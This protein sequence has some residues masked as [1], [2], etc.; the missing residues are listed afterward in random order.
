MNLILGPAFGR[1]D[2]G[3]AAQRERQRAALAGARQ[4][5]GLLGLQ[6]E[7]DGA[8]DEGVD[9]LFFLRRLIDRQ[10]TDVGEN[11]FGLDGVASAALRILFALGEDD[12]DAVVGQDE[13]AGAGFRRDFSGDG[14]HPGRQDRGHEAG[15][16]GLHQL[17]FADRLARNEGVARN[18]ARDLLGGLRA[19][20]ALDEAAARGR[21]RPGLPLQIVRLHR[22]AEADLVLGDENVDRL[23]LCD[24]LG[25][26]G[27]VV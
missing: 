6:F 22:L 25:R 2:I 12:V 11:D 15:T 19:V 1:V 7:R 16:V 17:G 24:G 14:A 18:R 5:L 4:R 20:G 10:H 9:A 3:D 26:S 8:A 21:R 27:L 23:Q 13:A